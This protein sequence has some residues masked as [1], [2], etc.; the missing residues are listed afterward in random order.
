M[1]YT[2]FVFITA[3]FLLTFA[4]CEEGKDVAQNTAEVVEPVNS[5]PIINIKVSESILFDEKL[6]CEALYIDNGDTLLLPANIKCRG[7][8]SSKYGKHSYAIEFSDSIKICGIEA[9]DDWVLNANYIDK[10]FQRHKLNYDL[11]RQMNSNNIAS[12][13]G[14]IKV[15]VNWQYHGLYVAM[16]E[17]NGGQLGVDK[18]DP[19]AMVFKDPPVFYP[20]RLTAFQDSGNYYQQKFPKIDVVD[21]SQYLNDFNQFLFEASNEDFDSKIETWIDVNN[22]IDWHLILLLSNNDDGLFKNFYLYKLNSATPMRIAIWDYDH[23]FGRDADGKINMMEREVRWEK[24]ILLQRLMESKTLNYPER[25]KN[26]WKELRANGVFTLENIEGLIENNTKLISL[27]LEGNFK[28]WPL[29]GESYEDDNSYDQEIE[30]I[31][32]FVKMRLSYL[33]DYLETINLN[34]GKEE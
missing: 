27:N 26:R 12:Q 28:I 1:R 18:T 23:S 33:D 9:D 5:I 3:L 8:M 31:K 29:N 24:V 16:Q 25:I 17:I 21:K 6:E 32:K 14:Y 2:P 19:E 13:S 15:Y 30:I 20:E 7:G 34:N 22:V 11:F 4:S 10:T